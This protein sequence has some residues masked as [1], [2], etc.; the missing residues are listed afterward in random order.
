MRLLYI[1]F[2]LSVTGCADYRKLNGCPENFVAVPGLAGYSAGFC[3]SK[4]EMKQVDGTGQAISQPKTAPW[5]NLTHATALAACRAMGEGYD[6]ITNDEWQVLAR[7]IEFVRWNWSGRTIGSAGGIN[8]GI[9][10]FN[11]QPLEASDDDNEACFKVPNLTGSCD[12]NTWHPNR[13]THILPNAQIIWDVAGNSASF[14]RGAVKKNLDYDEDSTD[15]VSQITDASYS[16]TAGLIIG[17]I[18][19][20]ERTAKGHF[21]SAGD[22]SELDTDPFGGLGLASK[23]NRD[24]Y[25]FMTR[26]GLPRYRV[27]AIFSMDKV[28]GSIHHQTGFRCVYHR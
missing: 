12:A 5:N 17:E 4:Y 10:S 27:G 20:V 16:Q 18:T 1:F 21:G 6:L 19:G 28:D 11:S 25:D 13:R 2:I 3:V 24:N 14:V 23:L 8:R 22:Y 9:F 26:G 7:N 15:Y